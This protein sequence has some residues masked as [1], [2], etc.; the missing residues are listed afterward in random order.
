MGGSKMKKHLRIEVNY[1]RGVGNLEGLANKVVERVVKNRVKVT[2]FKDGQKVKVQLL[3]P[4]TNYLKEDDIKQEAYLQ[5]WQYLQDNYNLEGISNPVEYRQY[6]VKL[7]FKA[8]LY[9]AV[10]VQRYILRNYTS[11]SLLPEESDDVDLPPLNRLWP[12]QLPNYNWVEFKVDFLNKQR[13]YSRQ[14]AL[15]A[16][17]AGYSRREIGINANTYSRMK[18]EL[19]EYYKEYLA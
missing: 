9:A 1:W 5:A 15:Y 6:L 16:L 14:K 13:N 8:A 2:R 17:L 7:Y 12:A 11:V 3:E 18:R 4:F 19:E 10:Q